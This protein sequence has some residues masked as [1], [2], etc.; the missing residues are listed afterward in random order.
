LGAYEGCIRYIDSQIGD[1]LTTLKDR[2][3]LK[4]TIVI[5]T[6]DHGES[7]GEHGLFGHGNSLYRSVIQVPLAVSFPPHLP[8]GL[9]VADPVSLR[10][11]PATVL[12]L[13]DAEESHR[14]PGVSLARY[15]KPEVAIG[16]TADVILAELMAPSRIPPDQG[17]SPVSKGP[18]K[19]LLIDDKQYIKNYGDG[20]EELYEFFGDP[21]EA[22][23]LSSLGEYQDDLEGLRRSMDQVLLE[24]TR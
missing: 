10:N 24:S 7:F 3:I 22:H 5:V 12:D 23:N 13:I 1:L 2:G 15:W 19:A 4:N 11:I 14:F 6:S 16:P 18:L 8:M 20:L 17:R 9:R 21:S